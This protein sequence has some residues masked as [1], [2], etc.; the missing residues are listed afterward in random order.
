MIEDIVKLMGRNLCD[1][2][3]GRV[4]SQLLTGYTDE[5]RGRAIRNFIGMMIDSGKL[6]SSKINVNN[7]YNVRFKQ[8]DLQGQKE[9]CWLCD[10]LFDGLDAMAEKAKKRL[11]KIEFKDFLVGTRVPDEV[12]VKEEKLWESIGIEYV[13]SIKS[14]LNREVGK[15]IGVLM[16]KE[17]NFKNPEIVVLAD[18]AN[19]QVLLQVNSL[20]I[21]G[22]YQKKARGIPQCKWGTPG[23]YKSSVQEIVAKPAMKMTK[24]SGN[25][26]HGMGREDVDARCLGWRS[27]VLEIAEPIVRSINLKKLQSEINKSGKVNVKGLKFSDRIMVVKIKTEKADKT[28][29][30]EVEFDKPVDKKELR[31]I[32]GLRGAISQQTPTRVIHRRA[33]LTRRRIVKDI[34]YKI[35]N[36]K[37]I[38]LTVKTNAGLYVKELVH[39]DSGRTKPSVAEVLGVKATPKNLDVLCVDVPKDI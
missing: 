37:K 4:Y 27:F 14:E 25:S 22:F 38:L 28:Y 2:C 32:L 26:F 17:T 21:F 39:G 11:E 8:V 3:L 9:K 23:R 36:R 31:K 34:K 16:D 35:I 5:E 33:D 6:D 10:D 15:R 12:L 13:E 30:V 7:F 20:Y 18:F 24:G 1:H 29:Q 19:D